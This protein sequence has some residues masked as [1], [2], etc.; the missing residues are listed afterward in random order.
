[1]SGSWFRELNPVLESWELCLGQETKPSPGRAE[2]CVWVRELNPGL[3]ELRIVSGS[4]FRKLNQILGAGN[5]TWIR[6]LN[7]VLAELGIV[8]GSWIRELNPVLGHSGF[9]FWVVLD[10]LRHSGI[11][12]VG[13][14]CAEALWNFF[15]WFW[16]CLMS[17]DLFSVA[18]LFADLP[19]KT[20]SASSEPKTAL[21]L[22]L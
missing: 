9:F 6:E 7:P 8:S 19:Q 2:N 13:S 12:W 11:F 1:M 20:P 15:G 10:V 21:G 3:A 17:S 4:W 14:L 16:M 5:S 18:I 22:N